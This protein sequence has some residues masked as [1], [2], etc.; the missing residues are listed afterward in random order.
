MKQ[1]P[2]TEVAWP[3]MVAK[4]AAAATIASTIL[5]PRLKAAMPASEAAEWPDTTMA[6]RPKTGARGCRVWNSALIAHLLWRRGWTSARV[7]KI[8]LLYHRR[9][10]QG[11]I[12]DQTGETVKPV[13]FAV[14]S[15]LLLAAMPAA[16]ATETTYE[17]KIEHPRYGDIGTYA[18]V[19]RAVGDVYEIETELHVAVK[20]LGIVMHR[21]DAKR[22]ERWQGDRLVSFEGVT[23]TNGDRL[24]ISGQAQG[25]HFVVTT[26]AG[27]ITA[28]ASVHPSNPW[29]AKNPRR[30]CRDVHEERPRGQGRRQW[31]Q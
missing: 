27:K 3:R 21:E 28:P 11:R 10:R 2:P 6:R 29:G 25:D 23:I 24:E 13:L 4:A 17:Y 20:V 8:E 1:S 9:R 16:G 5:P 31:R 19:V 18:N 14:L 12:C 30:R 22:T 26:P 7:P 15:L